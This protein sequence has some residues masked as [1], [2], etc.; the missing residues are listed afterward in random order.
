[1]RVLIVEDDFISRRIMQKMLST[2]GE[3]DIA[4]NGQEAI[5]AFQSAL[6]NGEPYELICLDIMLP[7]VDGQEVLRRAREYEKAQGVPPGREAR[8]IM[9]TAVDTPKEVI[10]AY[11][12]GGCTAYLVK[13]IEKAKLIDTLKQAGLF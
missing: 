8:I 1:M 11:Y 3:C 5:E 4:V 10:D 13:P 7:G 12:R 6:R 2:I 9:T